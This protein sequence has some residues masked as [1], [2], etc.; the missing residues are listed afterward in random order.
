MVPAMQNLPAQSWRAFLTQRLAN[1]VVVWLDEDRTNYEEI[2]RRSFA[3]RM[4]YEPSSAFASET[5]LQY[6]DCYGGPGLAHCGGSARCGVL[7]GLQLKG[8]GKTPLYGEDPRQPP[9]PAHSS[10]TMEI[11][12]AARETIWGAVCADALPFG[13]VRTLAMILTG[14]NTTESYSREG[15]LSARRAIVFRE[16]AIRPA[17]YMRN[18]MFFR[19]VPH[20]EASTLDSDRTRAAMETIEVE[21]ERLA[22]SKQSDLLSHGLLGMAERFAAQVATAFAKRI[23]HRALTASNIAF[24]GRYLDFGAT[25]SESAFRRR[26]AAPSPAALDQWNQEQALWQT[27]RALRQH[28]VRYALS[29]RHRGI[30]PEDL[31]WRHFKQKHRE[32]LIVEMLKL[33][34]IEQR[35]VLQW[36]EG[37]R[38]ALFSILKE[39]LQRG[40]SERFISGGDHPV[41]ASVTPM[42]TTGRYDLSRVLAALGKVAK[43]EE[44]ESALSVLLD[45]RTLRSDLVREFLA[46]RDFH[47]ATYAEDERAMEKRRIVE[48]AEKRN[49]DLGFLNRET[50]NEELRRLAES[51]GDVGSY[52]SEKVARARSIF[53]EPQP[54][55]CGAH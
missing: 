20:G 2:L 4:P 45:D 49:C 44:G 10:G 6:A 36:P 3:I 28:L 34:G 12:T 52:I 50:M 16:F 1:P 23:F 51:G 17:H 9:D 43:P 31:L 25:S 21:F 38:S 41:F 48:R 26:S 18:L 7:D 30:I 47:L 15:A 40:A 22:P 37:R 32:H 11:I 35:T 14:T 46:L 8:V 33:T 29:P 53:Q 54:L 27:L 24:D 55:Y 5:K 42:H 39:I 13:S 19:S